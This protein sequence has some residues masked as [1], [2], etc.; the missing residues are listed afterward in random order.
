MSVVEKRIL[1]Y[2]DIKILRWASKILNDYM[3]G[4]NIGRVSIVDK[5]KE[6]SRWLV[7]VLRRADTE[8]VKLVK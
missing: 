6:R 5:M 2:L 3:R 8:I 4:G 1:R 7:Y